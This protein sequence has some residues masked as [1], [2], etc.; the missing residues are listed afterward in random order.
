MHLISAQVRQRG[1]SLIEF[2]IAGALSLVVLA[3]LTGL[4]VSNMRARDELSRG[5]QQM[6]NGRFAMELIG[7]DLQLAGYY[8]EFD[9]RNADMPDP[10]A[11]TD[12]CSTTPADW[13]A[14]LPIF[15]R[16][17][18][19][20]AAADEPGCITDRKAGTDILVI[21]R[22]S[23]CAVGDAGCADVGGAPYFQAS[24]CSD[25][26]GNELDDTTA[27]PAVYLSWFR[28]DTDLVNLDRTRRDCTT[29]AA[30]RRF[31]T[32][33]YYVAN[34]D[35]ASGGGD[36]I[37]TLKRAELGPGGTF[38][39]V[40]L[41]NGI[42]NMQFEYGMDFADP[43]AAPPLNEPNGGVAVYSANPSQA[44]GADVAC[45]AR[46]WRNVLTVRVHVLART[47]TASPH[48]TES[49]SYVLGR[50]VG[51][52]QIVFTPPSGDSYKRHVYQTLVRL[53]NPVVRLQPVVG[54]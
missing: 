27:P 26:G 25:S 35:D 54:P 51:G 29:L 1:Y 7:N 36:G 32:H 38:S 52:T 34:N 39:V 53:N 8:G 47:T 17:Y 3:A 40:S 24:L 12:P 30:R 10:A 6:E 28:L 50:N 9:L 41:V 37:P 19:A 33:I 18:D 45:W 4:F 2:M 31:R 15:I 23:S 13:R 14:N 22:T 44:C 43:T 20:V 48:H 16:G 21:R 42:E 46:A 5:N 49:K 11:I